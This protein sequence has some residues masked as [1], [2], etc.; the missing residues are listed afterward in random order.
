MNAKY[1]SWFIFILLFIF[2]TQ[3]H[4]LEYHVNPISGND[5]FG[6]TISNPLK[7]I[8]EVQ[9]R[10]RSSKGSPMSENV[11]VYLHEGMYFLTQ[12]VTFDERDGGEGSYTVT[13]TRYKNEEPV[14]AGGEGIKG[15]SRYKG[16]V[17]SATAG[18]SAFSVMYENRIPCTALQNTTGK[19]IDQ[20]VQLLDTPGKFY[21]DK[22]SGIVYYFPRISPIPDDAVIVPGIETTFRIIGSSMAPNG[23][24]RK[25]IFTGITFFSSYYNPARLYNR[26]LPNPDTGLIY[27]ENAENISIT[28][29]KILNA[30]YSG[31]AVSRYAKNI[32]IEGNRV[33][34][35][36]A[37]GISLVGYYPDEGPFP[38]V[39][40]SNVNRDNTVRNNFIARCGLAFP[41]SAGI[42]VIQSGNNTIENNTIERIRGSGIVVTGKEG[43]V[44][45][46]AYGDIVTDLNYFSFVHS[47]TN[48]IKYNNILNID[49]TSDTS[50]GF[51]TR[52]AG[53]DNNFSNNSIH[54]IDVKVAK[55]QEAAIGADYPTSYLTISKNVVYANKAAD[56]LFKPVLVRGNNVTV[57]NN[58]IAYNDLYND[59]VIDKGEGRGNGVTLR[60]NITL[61]PNGRNFYYFENIWSPLFTEYDNNVFY[62]PGG[63]YQVHT[64]GSDID[65][66]TWKSL[67]SCDRNS[68]FGA[69]PL[70]EDP[71]SRIFSVTSGSPAVSRGFARID[72]SS[73]GV[74]DSFPYKYATDTIEAEHYADGSGTEKF[75][76]M[77]RSSRAGD[78]IRFPRVFFEQGIVSCEMRISCAASAGIPSGRIVEVR[79][80]GSTG[81]LL[82]SMDLNGT[83]KASIY[84]RIDMSIQSPPLQGYYD[85]YIVFAGNAVPV[86]LDY[87]RFRTDRLPQEPVVKNTP[88]FVEIFEPEDNA[89][90]P[91]G[92]EI[93][94]KVNA[95]DVDSNITNVELFVDN[96]R[97]F[98][99]DQPVFDFTWLADKIGAHTV[100][101]VA[102][103]SGGL[104][105]TS[106]VKHFTVVK[107]VNPPVVKIT[108]PKDNTIYPASPVPEIAIVAEA[109]DD[110]S[111]KEIVFYI[112]SNL[113]HKVD[114]PMDPPATQ[115][116]YRYR[117]TDVKGGDYEIKVMAR[118]YEDNVAEAVINIQVTST[119][120][121]ELI[122]YWEFES[123]N[124]VARDST[125]NHNDAQIESGETQPG[126]KGS[127][128]YCNGETS[129]RT[130]KSLMNN[131]KKFTVMG[132]IKPQKIT[133]FSGLWGQRGVIS[134]GFVSGD[135]GDYR[136]EISTNGCGI[137]EFQYEYGLKEWHHLA[138]SGNG[139]ALKLYVDGILR[140]KS[141][142]IV[143]NYGQSDGGFNIGGGGIWGD[144]GDFFQGW[145]DDV[146]LYSVALSDKE[147][148]RNASLGDN[149]LPT[150]KITQPP[151]M[152][153][154]PCP[155]D[156][157]IKADAE[158]QLGAIAHVDFKIGNVSY[159]DFEKPFEYTWKAT[160]PGGYTIKAIAFDDRGGFTEE[161][162]FVNMRGTDPLLG[163]WPF[164]EG[165]GTTAHDS[166]G[167][168]NDG[169]LFDGAWAQGI[170][171]SCIRLSGNGYVK[172]TGARGLLNDLKEFTLCGWVKPV[173]AGYRIGL[174]GQH[175]VVEFG[176]GEPLVI[177]LW[178]PNTPSMDTEYAFKLNEWH[179]IAAAGNG[180]SIILY[181]DGK[182]VSRSDSPVS[183]ATGY[184]KSNSTFNIGGSIFD[185]MGNFFNGMIDEVYVYGKA[186][187]PSEIEEKAR[188]Q[189]S[190]PEV[191]ITSPREGDT[192]GANSDIEVTVD[193]KDDSETAP[194][195]ELYVNK[196]FHLAAAE[197]PYSFSVPLKTEGDY[198]IKAK[199][200]DA[201]GLW[202]ED[203]IVIRVTES[204]PGDTT[205]T[206]GDDDADDAKTVTAGKE[207]TRKNAEFASGKHMHS[208]QYEVY[209]DSLQ[210]E[211]ERARLASDNKGADTKKGTASQKDTKTSS[212]K[213]SD[214]SGNRKGTID[215]KPAPTEPPNALTKM[216]FTDIGSRRAKVSGATPENA[217][218]FPVGVIA[219]ILLIC[220]AAS[221]L[222]ILV[223]K[224]KR[225]G[226]Q[227][228]TDAHA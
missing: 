131:R 215:K 138:I 2:T 82:G 62:H 33:D 144:N 172:V 13:Y 93:K 227:P 67:Y 32:I 60:R 43:I 122:A 108:E 92:K 127:V 197:E 210:Y 6:G 147:I 86:Q 72:Q 162:I 18:F 177:N 38:I 102:S 83:E 65:E 49:F 176:F 149:L 34:M 220:A 211:K 195:V 192:F 116:T 151:D 183:D 44:G 214:S 99:S 87:A 191:T 111:I 78:Y 73:M 125:D 97:V 194:T 136:L 154:F 30:A 171:G 121:E 109:S 137:L 63:F 51:Y 129:I 199:A 35:C 163:Y 26:N 58:V 113:V 146:K 224:Q 156:I 41:G 198:E 120:S 1:V 103:D 140:K 24:V 213:G 164:D 16:S 22:G 7:S 196:Q 31:I 203:A 143:D 219:S 27:I 98:A 40:D 89:V 5:S 218:G 9:K 84:S 205:S 48:S 75:V 132:W 185:S 115:A 165:S 80:N 206:S 166:S 208:T 110:K 77:I 79:V 104:K 179:H 126:I 189:S 158:D 161:S 175:G 71:E 66:D 3:G 68:S 180:E 94:I 221:A 181:Y 55:P 118:D 148:A 204:G 57:E 10:I 123:G 159:P 70:F 193:A 114:E 107:Q 106:P 37:H 222:L 186:L 100:H 42:L 174:W 47:R 25:M 133:N 209:A 139:Q 134:F 150:V 76:T 19:S 69:D 64:P 39:N 135:G 12:S 170:K 169:E 95:S 202:T 190:G 101:A 4:S 228:R 54:D 168:G 178:T 173:D 212:V 200:I 184:G 74:P 46:P 96:V 53:R 11:T 128:I 201:S 52:G 8:G 20:M 45:T 36:G 124:T 117:W 14:I 105:G 23:L 152:S 157:L 160:V 145:I 217:E 56:A 119:S 90:V 130:M 17:Y 226:K 28:S 207:K 91:A 188:I 142:G 85:L 112:N 225:N 59:F 223:I 15:W 153:T 29:S 187:T 81:T 141:D 61:T 21:H 167:Y 155:V 50:S 216:R 182:Q 88:P